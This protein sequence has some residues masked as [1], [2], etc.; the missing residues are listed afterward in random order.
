MPMRREHMRAPLPS[1]KSARDEPDRPRPS[2]SWW[3]LTGAK[4]G[5]DWHLGHY[6]PYTQEDHILRQLD[7]PNDAKLGELHGLLVD[8][9]KAS[10]QPVHI[11]DMVDY[12]A[13][14]WQSH[15]RKEGSAYYNRIRSAVELALDKG[16]RQ[17]KTLRPEY[18]V[19]ADDIKNGGDRRTPSTPIEDTRKS[20]PNPPD[21]HTES[22][23]HRLAAA[24]PSLSELQALIVEILAHHQG[25]SH[26]D[27]ICIHVSRHW[28]SLKKR[29]GAP[30]TQ[31]LR[32]EVTSALQAAQGARPIFKRD[33]SNYLYWSI[34]TE[35]RGMLQA[36]SINTGS[37]K[38]ARL[39]GDAEEGEESQNEGGEE[40][41]TVPGT[42]GED[43]RSKQESE[44]RRWEGAEGVREVDAATQHVSTSTGL[45][46]LQVLIIRALGQFPPDVA[47]S[48]E[49]V[50]AFV[51][52]YWKSLRRRDGT[53]YSMDVARGCL[54][55]LN[56]SPTIPVYKKMGKDPQT[57]ALSKVGQEKLALIR[58]TEAAMTAGDQ[59]NLK[60]PS[61]PASEESSPRGSKRRRQK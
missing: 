11:S 2:L 48:L 17:I 23:F 4:I 13:K 47:V 24:Q 25:R 28:G 40:E 32:R 15:R 16:H 50:V 19:L 26:L 43:D 58:R 37:I 7:E 20:P 8:C 21:T 38:F 56:N 42:E 35:A 29:D 44:G 52:P 49:Q 18:Y 34:T 22:F 31:D 33:E 27:N 30:Y 14:K 10:R 55:A 61:T 54:T 12:V 6:R 9:L 1:F 41:E 39:E 45:T 59:N 5:L 60:R 53:G 57:W 3:Y 51:R 36:I 46:D